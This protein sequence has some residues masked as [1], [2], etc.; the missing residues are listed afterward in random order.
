M[1][2]G[3]FVPSFQAPAHSWQLVDWLDASYKVTAGADGVATFTC[4]QLDDVTRW[5]ITRA[6][7]AS[8]STASTKL[9]LYLDAPALSTLR[10]GSDSGDYDEADYPAGLMIPPT[11]ALVAQWTGGNPGD[12]CYLNLQAEIMRL[13]G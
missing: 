2:S 1:T 11:R 12:T 8:T 4:P 9:R 7:V 6:V 3:I 10:S 5:R 13:V